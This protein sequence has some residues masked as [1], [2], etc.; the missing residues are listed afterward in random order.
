[1]RSYAIHASIRARSVAILAVLPLLLMLAACGSHS[2]ASAGG[3]SGSGAL[4]FAVFNPFSGKDASFGPE[5]LAGCI[6]AAAAINAA[7]GILGHKTVVCKT[8]D[9]RGD[10]ADA[11]PAAQQLIATT[12]SLVG[13]LG[14]S[15][16]EASSTVPF[17]NRAHIPMFGD[18]G[19][20]V[21]NQSSFKYFYRIT[22]PDDAVGY[23]MAVYAHQRG[24]PTAAAVFG[25][26]ISSQGSLATVVAGFKKLGGKIVLVQ[27][28]P[29]DQSS[30]R[31][32]VSALA[33]AHPSVIF[34]EADP[35]TSATYLAEVKQLG[36]LGPFIG[37]D[38]TT[39]PPWLKAVGNAVG[40]PNLKRYYVGAQPYAPTT[41][42]PYQLWLAQIKA[43]NGQVSQPAS[44]WYG[45]SY[46]MA[47][48]DSINL[49]A[50]A[51]VAAKSTNP[52]VFR[53]WIVKVAT[54]SP[55]AV[56]VHDFAQGKAALT[57]G[58]TIQYVGATGQISFDKWQNSPGAFSF[59]SSDG[60]TKVATYTAAQISA[61]K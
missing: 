55:G 26:D 5:Q 15:S 33:A 8:S 45:D 2:S 49:M 12:P 51:M 52:S 50:L 24:Y 56:V 23:A 25:N 48:W 46:S 59:V 39:Q 16:D 14:P 43:V 31:T 53:P 47:G 30:Y 28:I 10:P 29:L 21:F 6:P 9:S 60:S 13:V 54:P 17:F 4:T 42:A 22:P 61:A 32:E 37:T 19:Q 36:H 3:V 18:T 11:V 40:V 1:M 41:G 38:G 20:A 58:K 27:S 35:Q 7:G 57:H 34:T 44:Q